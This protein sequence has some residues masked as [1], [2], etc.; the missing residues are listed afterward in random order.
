M[1]AACSHQA[2]AALHSG[3][4]LSSLRSGSSCTVTPPEGAPTGTCSAGSP[5]SPGSLLCPPLWPA[6]NGDRVFP[7]PKGPRD[8]A[9]VPGQGPRVWWRGNLCVPTNSE[10][11]KGSLQ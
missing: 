3:W 8:L 4:T 7:G 6:T 11:P 1:R 9:R 2:P 10:H 5:R